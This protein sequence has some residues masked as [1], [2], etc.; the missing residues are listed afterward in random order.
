MPLH[1]EP[2]AE[3]CTDATCRCETR[4]AAAWQWLT[5]MPAMSELQLPDCLV[6]LYS[7]AVTDCQAC[8]KKPIRQPLGCVFVM[9]VA[10]AQ[11]FLVFLGNH[12]S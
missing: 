2:A 6:R 1:A 7:N 10:L 11:S 5:L 12:V 3:V 9:H 4:S 8:S